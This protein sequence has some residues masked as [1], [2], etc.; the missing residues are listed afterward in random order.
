MNSNTNNNHN[1]IWLLSD[2]RPGTFTQSLAL[3]EALNLK[4][5]IIKINYNLLSKIPN[6]LLK[7]KPLHF[8]K[9][10]L[11]QLVKKTIVNNQQPQIIISAGRKSSTIAVFLKN[12]FKDTKL[13]HIM[14]PEINY[15]KF[16]FVIL[17]NHDKPRYKANNVI[18]SVG[19]LNQINEQLIKKNKEKFKNFFD[20]IDKK[21]IVLLIG[22][23]SKNNHYDDISITK[24]CQKTSQFVIKLDGHLIILNSRR[25]TPN[26]NN[27]IK[28]NI[29]C[30][31][32]FFEWN[33]IKD[34]NPY[35]ASIGFGNCFIATGDSV[36]MI[37]ECCSTGKNVFIFDQKNIS[38]KKHRL[39][40]QQLYENNYALPFEKIENLDQQSISDISKKITNKKLSEAQR[41][42]QIILQTL[43][44]K[45]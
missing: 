22:G 39:F 9:N 17:P 35:L 25:T 36:S 5:Q 42:A 34:N 45:S 7:Y 2:D 15:N 8:N 12:K 21:I 24:L 38:S 10:Q 11:D 3:V 14:Q 26:I 30:P 19:S 28:K 44:I 18:F 1:V 32:T 43:K 6:F 33:K 31:Y 40:H 20:K 29:N 27:L 23:D 4:Y 16:D 41:I 13:I 37:S